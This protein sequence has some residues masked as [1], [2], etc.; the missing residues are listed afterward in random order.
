[1]NLKDYLDFKNYKC[2]YK[3][4]TGKHGTRIGVLLG[5][6]FNDQKVWRI[7]WSLRDKK[8]PFRF[9]KAK[10]INIAFG[11]AMMGSTVPIPPSIYLEYQRFFDR[12]SRYFKDCIGGGNT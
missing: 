2:I 12:C 7:G 6:A 4:I 8:D 5:C 10:A 1:M 3:F 11:R 9:D